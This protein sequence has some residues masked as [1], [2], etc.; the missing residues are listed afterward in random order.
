MHQE[1]STEKK[2]FKKISISVTENLFILYYLPQNIFLF[3]IQVHKNK[4]ELNIYKSFAFRLIKNSKGTSELRNIF[5]NIP[6]G[7]IY[8]E[9]SKMKKFM[10]FFS[11]YGMLHSSIK[12]IHSRTGEK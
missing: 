3:G 12:Y 1:K 10:K 4:S 2:I 11:S 7:V 8:L 9:R 5:M 6:T